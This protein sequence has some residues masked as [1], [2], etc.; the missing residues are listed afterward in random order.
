MI[1]NWKY[2]YYMINKKTSPTGH[3][4]AN[5]EDELWTI[6]IFDLSKYK[7][8]NNNFRYI[9]AAVDTFTRKAYC[10]PTQTKDS[11][12]IGATLLSIIMESNH[13]PRVILSVNDAAY[14]GKTF[15]KVLEHKK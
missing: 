11:D 2:N 4:T 5:L 9:F 15:Q 13:S 10:E 7:A 6:D 14:S 3:I 1:H 12:T 8:E